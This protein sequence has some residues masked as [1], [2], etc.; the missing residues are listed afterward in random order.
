M[1]VFVGQFT[2]YLIRHN[3]YVMFNDYL[4]DSLQI[5]AL[6]DCP[7]GIV[8]KRQDQNLG[9]LRDSLL[10]FPGSQAELIF[11]FQ[12]EYHR[13]CP[14]QNGTGFIGH[15]AGL[16]D[17]HLIPGVDHGPQ[18]YVNGLGTAHGDHHFPVP[19]ICNSLLSL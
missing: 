16:G 15:I 12:I 10:Q 17:N 9:L 11:R 7:G 19:G 8:G 1:P 2:V 3:K 14:R 4:R 18:T 6:H 5:L 13:L